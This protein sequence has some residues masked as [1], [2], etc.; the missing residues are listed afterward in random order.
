MWRIFFHVNDWIKVF[1]SICLCSLIAVL[2]RPAFANDTGSSQSAPKYKVGLSGGAGSG[3]VMPD[4]STGTM[5]YSIPIEV[6]FG[7]KGMDPGL[8]LTYRSNNGDSWVGFGWELE[9]GSIERSAKHGLSYTE[10]DGYILNVAGATMDLVNVNENEYRAKIE[11]VFFKVMKIVN[12]DGSPNYWEVF[13]K[14]GTKFTFGKTAYGTATPKQDDPSNGN[15]VFKWCL[16][17]VEDTNGNYMTFSYA[18]EV[19]GHAYEGQIYLNQISYTANTDG[20]PTTNYVKFHLESRTDAPDMYTVNF[21][22]RTAF[23]LKTIDVIASGNRV[24]AYK[25]AYSPSTSTERSI[26]SAVQ[27]YGKDASL[28]NGTIT[29]GSALPAINIKYSDENTSFDPATSWGEIGWG[30]PIRHMLGDFD[31]D[32]KTDVLFINLDEPSMN[33]PLTVALSTGANFTTSSTSQPWGHAGWG[34]PIRHM[35]GDFDGDGKTD[36]LFINLDEPSMNGPLTVALSTGANFTTSST[37]QPWGH[38]G[39]GDPIRHMLGDFNGD[40]KTD[41]LFINMDGTLTVALSTG[42]SFTTSSTPQPWGHAGWGDPERHMLGD[43]NG[44][45]KTDVLFINLDEPSMNGPLTVALSTGTGFT[46]SSTSQPWGHAGWGD[47]ER[48]MLGDFNGDGKTDVLFIN[49]DEVNGSLLVAVSN[50]TGF[51]PA[52]EWGGVGWGDPWR[53]KL[54]DFNGD[55]RSDVLNIN[56]NDGTLSV[57]F[58]KGSRFT[59]R[60][61]WGSMGWGDASRYNF[62]DFNGDGKIDVGHINIDTSLSVAVGSG[63]AVNMVSDILNG[64]GGNTN[65]TYKPS[66]QYNNTQLP[67]PIQTLSV[68]KNCENYDSTTSLCMGIEST[69]LYNYSGGYYH[70][71]EREFRGFNHVTVTGPAGP[72]GEQLVTET[73]FHRGNVTGTVDIAN[74]SLYVDN[75]SGNDGYMKGKPYYSRLTDAQGREYSKTT[76]LYSAGS[77]TPYFNPPEEVHSYLCDGDACTRETKSIYA[78]D[79]YGNVT[80]EEHYGDVT[81]ATDDRRVERTY[82]PNTD[83]WI[84]SLPASE[85]IYSG[86]TA[87]I[88]TAETTFYYDE[89]VDCTFAAMTPENQPPTKG[90]LTRIVRW[91]DGG[92]NPAVRMAYDAYGNL[93]CTRDPKGNISTFMYDN[94][95]TFSTTAK[96]PLG[97]TTL[98]QYYGIDGVASDNGLYGQV[99]KIT[100]PNGAV[101]TSQYDVF[102]RPTKTTTPDGGWINR[103]YIDF[104]IVGEQHV[105]ID[106]STGL[107]SWSYFDGMGRTAAVEKTGPDTK[108][109]RSVTKYNATGTVLQ[110]SLP[111]FEGIDDIVSWK[112]FTYDALGRNVRV[113]EPDGTVTLGCYNDGVTV[114]IDANG[115]RRRETRD[116]LGRLAKVEEYLGTFNDCTTGIESPY[117]TTT[118]QYDVL[119]NLLKVTDAAGNETRMRYDT[120][121]RK[122]F[123]HDPDMSSAT[124]DGE[125]GNWTYQYDANGNVISQK[126]AKGQTISFIYDKLNRVTNKLAPVPVTYYYDLPTSTYSKGRLSK[127]TDGS[128]QIVYHYDIKGRPKKTVK[129]I[130]AVNYTTEYGYDSL[131]RVTSIKYPD[132]EIVSYI[133][134]A[135]VLSVVTGSNATPYAQYYEYNPLGQA[136]ILSYG[137]GV[138]TTFEYYPGNNRLKSIQV[139]KPS[140]PQLLNLTYVYDNLGNISTMTDAIDSSRSQAFLYD[141]LNRLWQAQSTSYGTLSY[142]YDQIGNITSKE[143]LTYTYDQTGLKPH[144]VRTTL[145]DGKTYNYDPNGNMLTDGTRMIVYNEDNMPKSVTAY[146]KT[147]NFTYDYNGQRVKKAAPTGTNIYIGKHYE[148]KAGICSKYIFAGGVLVANKVSSEVMYYHQDHL[149]SNRVITNGNGNKMEEIQYMPFGATSMDT[150]S[151]SMAHKYTSQ[152]LDADTGLYYYNARYYNPVLGRFITA[153]TIVPNFTN[154]Q[155]LN[156]YSYVGNNPVNYADPTGHRRQNKHAKYFN[157]RYYNAAIHIAASYIGDEYYGAGSAVIGAYEAYAYGGH[158]NDMLK[159]AAISWGTSMASSYIMDW[160]TDSIAGYTGQVAASGLVGGASAHAQGGKFWNGFYMSALSSGAELIY[161]NSLTD[162]PGCNDCNGQ[163]PNPLPGLGASPKLNDEAVTWTTMMNWGFSN[164]GSG[165]PFYLWPLKEG[166]PVSFLANFIPGQNALAVLHDIWNHNINGRWWVGLTDGWSKW[167]WFIGSMPLS[168]VVTYSALL[169]GTASVS[170]AVDQ[171]DHH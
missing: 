45:G 80:R 127:V 73:W 14:K 160:E 1:L 27:Q 11:G 38:A 71:G 17:T 29:E 16:D 169:H 130:T 121:S 118:Y 125:A 83:K 144:A 7:R 165:V 60:Y 51:E 126:D 54:G 33:G 49:I 149:G 75:P 62:G 86:T 138:N 129:T 161:Q 36:V 25:L 48:H 139:G 21:R 79:A 102:G 113:S 164:R 168:G 6:P 132:Q 141:E 18:K 153:D 23:R 89:P 146:G 74:P 154:P 152:E 114:S 100:D 53:I 44:D 68:I 63:N 64:I 137:N 28:D 20:T 31:G 140:E 124:D 76:T 145:P 78:Y 162:V 101:T 50:G 46:T 47:P 108:T 67:F 115:H 30:D 117:A 156:R 19:Q 93:A 116:T 85:T 12:L 109:I 135:E 56:I 150:G 98:T 81:D 34:D 4:L 142:D 99:R 106:T 111:Y 15:R 158:F 97:H 119:G 82:F 3:T 24:R 9:V 148:C 72:D 151:V 39:W 10:T 120:L 147:I 128:G 166:G 55:G 35:L 57:I 163:G 155:S 159:S 131:D 96:N 40:G 136:R 95:Y 105:R 110:T 84:L 171:S 88:K 58:S 37:S 123:M 122:T 26:L 66:S 103:S 77:G 94:S 2:F 134:D 133:Y 90:N 61:P 157:N 59:A 42:T 32:G 104:G 41:V 91:L 167:P 87:T 112:T 65:I 22:V 170:L 143:G 52:A 92:T 8:A 13:D 70:I 107:F 43:F 69:T 5:S